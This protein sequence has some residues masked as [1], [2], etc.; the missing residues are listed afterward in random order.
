MKNLSLKYFHLENLETVFVRKE[1]D[2]ILSIFSF[3]LAFNIFFSYI[4]ITIN[5]SINR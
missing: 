4:K 3:F 2:K 5:L 1:V